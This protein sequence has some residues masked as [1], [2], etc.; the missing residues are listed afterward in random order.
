MYIIYRTYKKR[1]IIKND[2]LEDRLQA[3]LKA[4]GE[5]A[6]RLLQDEV[7][8]GDVFQQMAE[9]LVIRDSEN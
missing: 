1:N 7:I 4:L 8:E 9:E 3:K 6:K 2:I 5:I